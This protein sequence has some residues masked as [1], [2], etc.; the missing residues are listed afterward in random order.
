MKLMK[1][2]SA[3][4][5]GVAEAQPAPWALAQGE[6]AARGSGAAQEPPSPSVGTSPQSHPESLWDRASF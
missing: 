2:G 1:A 5:S 3:D 6:R 4:P